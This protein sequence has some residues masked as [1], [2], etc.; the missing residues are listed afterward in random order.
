MVLP[1]FKVNPKPNVSFWDTLSSSSGR[2]RSLDLPKNNIFMQ[3]T[4]S[5]YVQLC[6]ASENLNLC[7]VL[8]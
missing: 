1:G 3:D 2:R 5:K 7:A 4:A 8:K 6:V